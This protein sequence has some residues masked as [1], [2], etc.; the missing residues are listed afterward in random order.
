M[1]Q[2]RCSFAALAC[3]M[4]LPTFAQGDVFAGRL[5]AIDTP[6][7]FSWSVN[8]LLIGYDYLDDARVLS[9]GFQATERLQLGLAFPNYDSGGG[10]SSGNELS[11]AYRLLNETAISP[12]LT[13][14]M[15]GLG[16]DDRGAGEYVV[17]GKS[18]GNLR[19]AVGLGWGRYAGAFGGV[20]G[21]GEDTPFATDHLFEGENAAFANLR[22]V[23]PLDGLSL[24]A[25]YEDIGDGIFAAGLTYEVAK[26]LTVSAFANSEDEAGLRLTFVANPNEPYIPRNAR[27]GPHPFVIRSGTNTPPRPPEQVLSILQERLG[28]EDISVVRFSMSAT[29]IDV[30]VST[31]DD[32]NI[33]RAAGRTARVLSAIAPAEIE[34]FRVSRTN[35]Q[36]DTLVVALDRAGLEEAVGKVDAGTLAWNAA[37]I[38]PTPLV[39]TDPLIAP[40]YTGGFSYDLSASFKADFLTSDEL[41][42]TGTAFLTGRYNF[43]RATSARATLAYRFLNQWEQAAPPATPGIRSDLTSYTPDEIYLNAATV[44][45]K[46]RLSPETYARVSAGLF[47]RQYGGASAEVIWRPASGNLAFGLEGTY[48]QKRDYEDWFA[49]L[50]A[51]ATTVIGSVYANVGSMGDFVEVDFGQYL[52]GDF[53]VGLT[54]GRS[55]PNGWQIAA[56]TAWSDESDD[57]LR[58]GASLRVPLGWTAPNAGNRSISIGLGG[59]SGD[60]AS[61]VG[62]TGALYPDLQSSDSQRIED[63]WGQF[64]N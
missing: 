32:T 11:L 47:E 22:W 45:H 20:R 55:F 53:G 15:V 41:Q 23:T 26:D 43:T 18:F 38:E 28:K 34:T 58:F 39:W 56:N 9:F 1:G 36:F 33:A 63:A 19:T 61:R 14:G 44:Q 31:P 25:E 21:S 62:G 4:L 37:T 40:E 57:A 59:P 16:N 8:D 49:F 10:P 2:Q 42:P 12:S 13:I 29:A 5:D 51:D 30:T 17:A 3:A 50:D 35:G 46:F 64:W 52:A 7:A 24:L 27:R 6:G 54:V 60:F 48:V